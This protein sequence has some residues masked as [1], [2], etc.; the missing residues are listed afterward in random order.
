MEIEGEPFTPT[1]NHLIHES[2]TLST[3]MN[4]N[5]PDSLRQPLKNLRNF[6][7]LNASP[8]LGNER[9]YIN[10]LEEFS[11]MKLRG[12]KRRILDKPNQQYTQEISI[13]STDLNNNNLSQDLDKENNNR[14]PYFFRSTLSRIKSA[15]M[16][17]L[18]L[19]KTIKK[20][21]TTNKKTDKLQTSTALSTTP[22]SCSTSST[23]THTT[24][25]VQINK[26]TEILLN[27]PSSNDDLIDSLDS[28][29]LFKMSIS[30]SQIANLFNREINQ[31]NKTSFDNFW[32]ITLKFFFYFF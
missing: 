19:N 26:T 17:E 5:L 22:S 2:S 9:H 12:N 27:T 31:E 30:Q 3:A 25:N 23:T 16:N 18:R 28:Q 4:P 8:I 11:E 20:E 24:P 15:Q 6:E 29:H 14:R 13:N 1:R 10:D 7:N 32:K 21:S